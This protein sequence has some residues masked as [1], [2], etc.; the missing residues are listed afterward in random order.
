M[1]SPL[2]THLQAPIAFPAIYTSYIEV[3]KEDLLSAN[4]IKVNSY[5]DFGYNV[6]DHFFELN[7]YQN[8]PS[9]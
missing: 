4:L 2:A 5:K 6:H 9:N 7:L 1:R 8:D 3:R